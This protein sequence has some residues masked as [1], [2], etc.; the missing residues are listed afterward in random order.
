MPTVSGGSCRQTILPCARHTPGLRRGPKTSARQHLLIEGA[1][2]GKSVAQAARDAGYSRGSIR[3]TVYRIM[4]SPYVRS[5]IEA[6]LE[7]ANLNTDEIIGGYV[8]QMRCDIADLI[9]DCDILIAAQQ[10]GISHNIKRV[11]KRQKFI[12][13]KNGRMKREVWWDIDIYSAQQAA[14]AL[15]R[16]LDLKNVIASKR[17]KAAAA[18]TM[19]ACL[20]EEDE[21][22][23][24]SDR[25]LSSEVV[26]AAEV[27]IEE[28]RAKT[29]PAGTMNPSLSEEHERPFA[30][31]RR[32]PSEVVEPAE[33]PI[34]ERTQTEPKS[35]KKEQA[36][37]LLSDWMRLA[38]R[39]QTERFDE[40]SHDQ[41]AFEQR[42]EP[43]RAQ[44]ESNYLLR[45]DNKLW[46][47]R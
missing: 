7:A 39:M 5:R 32:L 29:G 36:P 12:R 43:R 25:R 23:F 27:P 24:A 47:S 16:I 33:V 14:N 8:S 15:A 21:R 37:L 38:E 10:K 34:E 9:P 1:L 22:P 45:A 19:N 20:T 41:H 6:H 17:A 42:I 35:K 3:G 18:E 46:S 40:Q 13:Q 26:Q 30:R 2:Q 44:I 4:K 11:R 31:D 28:R